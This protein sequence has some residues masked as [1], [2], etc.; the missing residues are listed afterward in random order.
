MKILVINSGSSSLKY[1]LIEMISETVIVEGVCEKIGSP[2]SILRQTLNGKKQ[3]TKNVSGIKNHKDAFKCI[4]DALLDKN[5]GAITS[6]KEISAVG[7][8]VVHGGDFFKIPALIN[9]EA[10][11]K[12]K[13]LTKLAPL[14]NPAHL[15]GIL[16]CKVLLGDSIPQVAVFDTSFY[17]T[18]PPKAYMFALPY[19]FYEKYN[20]RKYG[21]HGTSH[22]YVSERYTEITGNKSAKII[23]CHLGNGSSITAIKNGEAIETSM[24]LTPLGGLMMGTRSGSVDPSAILHIANNE[25][26]TV[27]QMNKML[28]QF[29]GL[30][31]VSGV[32]SDDRE[33]S[34]AEHEGNERAKLA[35]EMMTYQISK[36]IGA[37]IVALQGC[38]SIIFTGGIGEHQWE[39]REKICDS[40]NFMGI[41]ID[42][43]INKSISDNTQGKINEIKISTPNSKV[44]VWVISTNE[45]LEI[46]RETKKLLF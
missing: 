30:L 20:I 9:D 33:I 38:D 15:S 34:K 13:K 43:A 11:E 18:L 7:H 28:N 36:F 22:K 14:H 2:T 40:L 42:K 31:G 29:S 6:L 25:H 41:E 19:K 37:Y 44:E 5:I 1:K 12:I 23:S 35:H 21:F 27:H 4:E 3:V 32:S 24:G 45:E 8:R 46:A 10:I 16:A 26:M 39:H 17:K